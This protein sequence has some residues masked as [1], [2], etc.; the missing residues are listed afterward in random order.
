MMPVVKKAMG[1]FKWGLTSH[2]ILIY[3][4][5]RF[6]KTIE[7]WNF[8]P[9]WFGLMNFPVPEQIGIFAEQKDSVDD[10]EHSIR[11]IGDD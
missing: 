2:V 5:G 1:R 7:S 11:E 8:S 10:N 4:S 6:I 9:Y 3:S